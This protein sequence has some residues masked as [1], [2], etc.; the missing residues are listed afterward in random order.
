MSAFDATEHPHRRYNPLIG[1]WVLVS[2]HRAKRPWQGQ[3]ETTEN[4]K[5]LSYDPD[6]YLC[7]DNTRAGGAVNPP[8]KKTFVFDNDFAALQPDTPEMEDNDPLFRIKSEQGVSKVICFT[9]DHSKTLPLMTKAELVDVIDTW[10]NECEQLG[11]QYAW[12][13]VFENKGSVMGCSN[14]HPHGQIWAQSQLPTLADKKL[15][16]FKSYQQQHGT[17]LLLDYVQREQKTRE[18]IVVENDDWLVVVPFWAAWPFE[19]LLL[20]NFKI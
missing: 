1:E 8:Y 3:V 14:P 20:P 2:P 13:Q 5:P 10:K 11:E 4:D 17:S 15:S 18:R 7:A 6:C 19:T 16:S 12:V 9:P